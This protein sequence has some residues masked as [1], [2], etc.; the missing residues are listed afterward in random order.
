VAQEARI[1]PKDLK[2]KLLLA[3]TFMDTLCDT[4]QQKK[5]ICIDWRHYGVGLNKWK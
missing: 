3:K 4:L 5:A 1:N 2:K